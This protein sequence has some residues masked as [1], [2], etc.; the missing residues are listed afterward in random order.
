MFFESRFVS[1]A[2]LDESALLACA[3]YVDL[4][5]V[6]AGIADTPEKS[7]HTSIRQRLIAY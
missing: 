4:N 7:D 6:R 5:P 2:L 3:V 1:Q